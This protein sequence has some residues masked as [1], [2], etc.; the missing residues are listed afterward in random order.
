MHQ[1]I[2]SLSERILDTLN[3]TE[4]NVWDGE[5]IQSE[6][7]EIKFDNVHFSYEGEREQI[8]GVSFTVPKNS[9]TAIVGPRKRIIECI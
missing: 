3:E 6:K 8:K 2:Y 4:E 9:F 5:K 1:R 7:F